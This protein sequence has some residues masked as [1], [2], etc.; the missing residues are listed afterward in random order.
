M[1]VA[2]WET[3][4]TGNLAGNIGWPLAPGLQPLMITWDSHDITWAHRL[5]GMPGWGRVWR[6]K[7]GGRPA[8]WGECQQQ[9]ITLE[10]KGW[11]HFFNC[12]ILWAGVCICT[13]GHR[14]KLSLC[15]SHL[16]TRASSHFL[17]KCP[18]K[19]KRTPIAKKGGMGR[20]GSPLWEVRAT[21]AGGGPGR[22]LLSLWR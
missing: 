14:E 4:T 18:G 1:E 21:P 13:E 15:N 6:G 22:V 19:K 11:T 10:F 16:L 3:K 7:F 2:P 8:G 5:G 9:C 17:L 20:E 12:K